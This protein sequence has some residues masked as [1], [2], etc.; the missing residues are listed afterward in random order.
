[1]SK[2]ILRSELDKAVKA[3][4]SRRR[5]QMKTAL[6]QAIMVVQE[7]EARLK[8]TDRQLVANPTMRVGHEQVTAAQHTGEILSEALTTF[9]SV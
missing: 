4:N 6:R 5:Q 2:R 1:M 3:S 9:R 8:N 7:L